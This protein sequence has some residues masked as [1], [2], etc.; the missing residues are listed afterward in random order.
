[1]ITLAYGSGLRVSEIVNLIEPSIV[2]AAYMYILTLKLSPASP[3]L[4]KPGRV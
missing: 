4:A 2:K 3:N 1:M